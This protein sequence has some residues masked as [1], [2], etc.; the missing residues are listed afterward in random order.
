MSEGNLD[1]EQ[2][3]NRLLDELGRTLGQRERLLEGMKRTR[4]QVRLHEIT[5]EA[6]QPFEGWDQEMLVEDLQRELEHQ[7]A[8]ELE[9]QRVVDLL[10]RQREIENG[11]FEELDRHLVP[12][13]R[14][15]L[16]ELWRRMERRDA[17]FEDIAAGSL[18]Q[19]RRL[20]WEA[21]RCQRGLEDE[22]FK[23][24][25]RHLARMRRS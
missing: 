1:H 2:E 21:M 23:L 19:K 22:L 20:I 18:E 15:D 14:D 16:A 9:L 6:D 10:E 17:I 5:V 8:Q 13:L 7:R 24:I 12:E 25:E 11:L 3:L 4:T